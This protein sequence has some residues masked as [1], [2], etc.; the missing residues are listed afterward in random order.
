MLKNSAPTSY[1]Q[2]EYLL[3][4][5]PHNRVL[6]KEI[7]LLYIIAQTRKGHCMRNCRRN[8]LVCVNVNMIPDRSLYDQTLYCS[9]NALNYIKCRVIG[10]T[11]KM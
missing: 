11:L 4:N 1:K 9:T 3:Q 8:Q 2:A 10:N 7:M 5:Q 6:G